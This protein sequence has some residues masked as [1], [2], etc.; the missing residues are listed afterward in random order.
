[1]KID[2]SLDSIYKYCIEYNKY[3][4]DLI[5]FIYILKINLYWLYSLKV[6]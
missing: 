3:V 6:V 4:L 5:T 2:Y 1:M